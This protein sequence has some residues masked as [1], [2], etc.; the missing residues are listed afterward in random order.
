MKTENFKVGILGLGPIGLT[1]A[2]HFK[3][4]GCEVAVCDIDKKKLDLIRNGGIELVGKL[5]KSV[6]LK[7]VYSSVPEL[8]EHKFDILI[9]A[10]KAYHVDSVLDQIEAAYQD[11]YLLIAQNGID[12]KVKYT[13]HFSESRIFRMIVNYAGNLQAPNV[14]NITFFNPPNY[15]GSVNDSSEDMAKYLADILTSQN[16]ETKCVNSFKIAEEAWIKTILN[17]A[18]SP[19]CAISGHTMKEAMSNPGTLEIVEQIIIEAM[20]VAK[21]EDIIFQQNFIKLCLRY[22]NSAGN[23]FPSLAVDLMNKRE[24]EIDYM[25]GKIVEYGR[26]FYIKTPINLVFT[27]LVKAVTQMNLSKNHSKD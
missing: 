14:V 12:I 15:I 18:L 25:N 23:H 11:L 24:T 10:V 2:V 21:K 16:L 6:Y 19:L 17:A 27:N 22:L 3:N 8:L 20:E 26:K 9:S 1:L 5:N 13:S 7:H 4:A